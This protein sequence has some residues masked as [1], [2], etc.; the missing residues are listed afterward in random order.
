MVY[1]CVVCMLSVCVHV[2]YLQVWFYHHTSGTGRATSSNCD[3]I[4]VCC[5]SVCMCYIYRFGFIIIPRVQEEP[6][7]PTVMVYLCVVCVLS[8][9]CLCVHVLYLQVW[10][11]HYTSGTGR[12]ASSNCDGISVCCLCVHVLYLQVCF[13]HHT[14]GTG[15]AASSNCDG[16]SVCCLCVCMCYIY[17]FGFIIIPRV[18]EEPPLPTVTVY[19]CVVCVCACVI[20]TGLVLSSYLGYRKS[21]LF[22]L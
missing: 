18:Q 5:L 16:I 11:Y 8:V 1:L 10:F 6:P 4:S 14:S 12:A 7:L 9:C 3:G 19:L 13:Y 15:R 2:L 21:H 20:F 22:Q 17:R